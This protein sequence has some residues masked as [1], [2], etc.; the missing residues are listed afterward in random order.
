MEESGSQGLDE[1]VRRESLK[2]GY[3][4]GVDCVCIV[5]TAEHR[6]KL[7]LTHIQSD[8]YWLNTRTPALTYSLRGL[9]Y[10][11][12]TVAGPPRDLHSGAFGGTVHEP[13]TDLITLLGTLVNSQGDII[14]KGIDDM[15]PP[16]ADEE[17]YAVPFFVLKPYID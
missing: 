6:T 14:I 3:F 2:G 13:M 1:L 9:S 8:N 11:K 5:S 17:E 16:P 4:D 12:I 7:W 15:V 10:Y